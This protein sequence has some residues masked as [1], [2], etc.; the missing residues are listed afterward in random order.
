VQGQPHAGQLLL[1]FDR[2]EQ[3]HVATWIDSFHTGTCP[4]HS[5]GA[6]GA[7]ITVRGTYFAGPG[8]PR[9]GWRT[10]LDDATPNVLGIRM[11]NV[12]PTGKEDAAVLVRLEPAAKP[13]RGTLRFG[14]KAKPTIVMPAPPVR[15][16][17]ERLP[18]V[19]SKKPAKAAKKPAKPAKKAAKKK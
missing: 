2:A 10:E 19:T 9:W 4:M 14:A 18:K 11:W 12:D 6:A 5:T 15:S 7:T 13:A 8:Q 16:R 1:G 17:S 3:Q